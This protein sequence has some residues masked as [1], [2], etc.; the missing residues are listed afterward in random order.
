MGFMSRIDHH[1]DLLGRMADTFSVDF[2][3]ALCRGQIQGEELR[4]AVFRCMNCP[5]A[6]A[7]Q[8][9]IEAH[10]AGAAQPPDYCQNRGL[11]ARL[12]P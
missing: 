1:M 4:S 6:D 9:W 12:R 2:A 7:C 3:E 10:G 11:L 5:R 8:G